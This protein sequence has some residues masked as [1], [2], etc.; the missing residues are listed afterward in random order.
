MDERKLLKDER[1]GGGLGDGGLGGLREG[2]LCGGRAALG[3]VE[4]DQQRHSQNARQ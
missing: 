4:G 2:V 1:L 3:G